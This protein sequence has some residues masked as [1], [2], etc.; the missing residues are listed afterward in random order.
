[1]LLDFDVSE[2]RFVAQTPSAYGGLGGARERTG[3]ITV[4]GKKHGPDVKAPAD[5]CLSRLEGYR[6]D[7]VRL[8]RV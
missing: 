3:E 1:M 6:P 7:V 4:D 5:G 8:S 2:Y